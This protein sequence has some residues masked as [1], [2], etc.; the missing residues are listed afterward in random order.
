MGG[1]PLRAP[2]S[3]LLCV[4]VTIMLPPL[5]A[6]VV[7]ASSVCHFEGSPEI[8]KKAS[9]LPWPQARIHVP[10]GLDGALGPDMNRHPPWPLPGWRASC[11]PPHPFLEPPHV[12]IHTAWPSHLRGP[13]HA[14]IPSHGGGAA[15][16]TQWFSFR[17]D[18]RVKN[19]GHN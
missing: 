5:C 14:S 13:C 1:I 6:T 17:V 3:P 19:S 18:E 10:T 11:Q 15:C 2:L 9:Y 8:C 7:D 4:L 12:S 16:F